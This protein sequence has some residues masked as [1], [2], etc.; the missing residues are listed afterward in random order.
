MIALSSPTR[1]TTSPSSQSIQCQSSLLKG[2]ILLETKNHT[3]WGAAV[4]AQMYLPLKREQVWQQLVDYPRWQQYFPDV[5]QSRILSFGAGSAS[6]STIEKRL[7][8]AASKSFLFITAQ[9]E[10]YLRVIETAGQRIQFHFESGSFIDFEADLDLR[11]Y[12]DG[13]LLTYFVQASPL[14]PIPSVFI[15]QAIQWDL[16]ANMRNMR[17]VLC[18]A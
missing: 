8:Q 14:I 2:E 1:T 9:V 11:D 3:A 18:N 13:T 12:L 16:P 15:Q 6:D 4:T 10:V 17:Q 7:Y 5:T